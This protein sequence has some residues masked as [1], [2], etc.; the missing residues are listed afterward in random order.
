MAQKNQ[1]GYVPTGFLEFDGTRVPDLTDWPEGGFENATARIDTDQGS[2]DLPSGQLYYAAS[3]W[4][5]N[6][7]PLGKI[8]RYYLD[9]MRKGNEPRQ[10]VFILTDDIGDPDD[11]RSVVERIDLGQCTL[12]DIKR[13]AGNK[14]SPEVKKVTIKLCIQK[15]EELPL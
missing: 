9:W 4:T 7:D 10:G 5:H 13:N 6:D 12:A 3:D 11:P 8:R 15:Y 1:Q 2:R 14:A